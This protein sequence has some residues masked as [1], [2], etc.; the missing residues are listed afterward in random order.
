MP[1]RASVKVPF[2]VGTSDTPDVDAVV[3]ELRELYCV[4]GLKLALAIGKLVLDRIYGGDIAL[5]HSRGRKDHSFRTLAKHPGL[6]F[7]PST[8]SRAVGIYGISLRRNDLLR[9]PNVTPSHMRE[10]LKLPSEQQD[11]LIDQTS[12]HQWSVRQL[13]HE[14]E[15]LQATPP[16][17]SQRGRPPKFAKFLRAFGRG[18]E[19]AVLLQEVGQVQRLAT[20]EAEELLR[21]LRALH[22]Q[23][24][25]VIE[26]VARH[27]A[28]LK[29]TPGNK[30]DE[31]Q[32]NLGDRGRSDVVPR[33]LLPR[34]NT[35]QG[36]R[37][38]G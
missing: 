38:E 27:L 35:G 14:I 16:G 23:T 2:L 21:T 5:W 34:G 26:H 13:R 10:L 7:A 37:A 31:H 1:R 36:C 25:T 18:V 4:A 17:A 12:E 3:R 24:E 22:R 11:S 33:G 9:L 8:L 19:Q 32:D 28:A 15:Q 29:E 30:R 20:K 6:P